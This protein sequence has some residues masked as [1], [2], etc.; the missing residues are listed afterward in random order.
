M[1]TTSHTLLQKLREPDPMAAWD[2]FVRLYSPGLYSWARKMGLPE[3]DAADLVQDVLLTLVKTLPEFEYDAGKSFR[4]W[5]WTLTKNQFLKRKNR[6]VPLPVNQKIL[7]KVEN[8]AE[9]PFWEEEYRSHMF[10]QIVTIIEKE[11]PPATWNAFWA[12]VV[13]G[14]SA[15]QVSAEHGI[16]LWAVYTAKTRVMSHLHKELAEFVPN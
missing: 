1:H 10:S 11:F 12:H 2:R 6:R 8:V 14:K 5:L 9:E 7:D 3:T 4:G 16:N 15:S 13:E